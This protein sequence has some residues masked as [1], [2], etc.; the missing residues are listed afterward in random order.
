MG[1][2]HDR[3][4]ISEADYLAGNT[5]YSAD[6]QGMVSPPDMHQLVDWN[7]DAPANDAYIGEE[8]TF[9]KFN[10]FAAEYWE[11]NNPMA[12]DKWLKVA[13]DFSTRHWELLDSRWDELTQAEQDALLITWRTRQAGSALRKGPV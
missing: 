11:N 10:S 4:I 5:K 1:P 6:Y 3:G 9:L 12:R 13:T 7:A 2:I 8:A